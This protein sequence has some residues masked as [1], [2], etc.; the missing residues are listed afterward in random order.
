MGAKEPRPNSGQIDLLVLGWESG[1][2]GI[3]GCHLPPAREARVN[4][5]T[6]NAPGVCLAPALD[7]AR[8]DDPRLP[9]DVIP[10]K[11][12]F[13]RRQGDTRDKSISPAIGLE[14]ALQTF[15]RRTAARWAAVRRCG[16]AIL[17]FWKAMAKI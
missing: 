7:A 15:R 12:A 16:P 2:L 4:H 9:D 6:E 14:P 5:R 17:P 13:H 8:I 10:V 3:R 11:M 1:T